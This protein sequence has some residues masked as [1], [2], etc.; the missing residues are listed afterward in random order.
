MQVNNINKSYC[1][2]EGFTKPNARKNTVTLKCSC[3]SQAK[4]NTPLI[5]IINNTDPKP[6]ILQLQIIG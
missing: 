5:G 2:T 3:G 4:L 6:Q 1:V